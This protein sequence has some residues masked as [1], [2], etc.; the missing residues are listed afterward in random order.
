MTGCTPEEMI[1]YSNSFEN[2]LSQRMKSKK[3]RKL[4]LRGMDKIK[5]KLREK[6]L[7]Y[8]E[9]KKLR[10]LKNFQK[11]SKINLIALKPGEVRNTL[12]AFVRRKGSSFFNR[13]KLKGKISNFEEFF[14][15]DD[16]SE[17]TFESGN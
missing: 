3:R 5:R 1:E 15:K 10:V 7:G 6:R 14:D 17:S 16:I 11:F 13:K 2:S 12:K 9:K 4:I 8:E